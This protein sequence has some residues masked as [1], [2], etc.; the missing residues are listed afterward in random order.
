MF[1]SELS[2]ADMKI[3]RIAAFA[4]VIITALVSLY[5][6][7]LY[8]ES[9]FLDMTTARVKDI[10]QI[11]FGISMAVFGIVNTIANWKSKQIWLK[12]GVQGSI[13]IS[14]ETSN[15]LARTFWHLVRERD[16][17]T[18]TKDG[19]LVSLTRQEEISAVQEASCIY[20]DTFQS[21]IQLKMGIPAIS[22]FLASICGIR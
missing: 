6:S 14:G 12:Y 5:F 3:I 8:K 10:W 7:L 17:R 13:K 20:Q 19:D 21:G 4:L 22:R 2:H 15:R 9:T 18:T 1:N 16:L 11:F